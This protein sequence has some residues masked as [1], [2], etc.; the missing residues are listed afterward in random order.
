METAAEII[1]QELLQR[2]KNGKISN[3]NIIGFHKRQSSLMIIVQYSCKEL[4]INSFVRI[5]TS[6]DIATLY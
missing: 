2:N 6:N 1:I 3:Y 4:T 5:H